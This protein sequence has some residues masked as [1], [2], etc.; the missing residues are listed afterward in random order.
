MSQTPNIVCIQETHF[1]TDKTPKLSDKVFP[2][3]FHATNKQSKTKGVFILI[4]K[5]T[6]FQITDSLSDQEGRY[7]F[8]KGTIKSKP[9]IIAHVYAPNTKQVAFFRNISNL[10][11]SLSTGILI[12]GG[13]FNVPLN[14]LLDTSSGTS[15]MPYRALKQI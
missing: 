5:N 7:L 1:L 2:K 12:L 9:I 13:D 3:A 14:P 4:S 8:L 10:L 11:S 6:P 15:T